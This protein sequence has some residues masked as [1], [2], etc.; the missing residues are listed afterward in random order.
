MLHDTHI[1][2]VVKQLLAKKIFTFLFHPPYS[3][4]LALEGYFLF[5]KVKSNFKATV[6]T[7]F[8]TSRT[9]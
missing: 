3:P 4:D 7:A 8:P 2:T 1:A 5:F 6:L 9:M